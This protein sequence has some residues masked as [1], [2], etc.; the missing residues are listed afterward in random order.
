M[1][2]HVPTVAMLTALEMVLAKGGFLKASKE[3]NLSAAAISYTIKSLERLLGVALFERHADGVVPTQAAL[4]LRDDAKDVVDRACRLKL[5]AAAFGP[6]SGAIRI[7]APQ[8][9]ASLWL[10][11]RM[12]ELM[13]AFP[14]NRFEIISWLGGST[15]PRVEFADSVHLEIRWSG[16]ASLP[17]GSR[18]TLLIRD[19]AVAVASPRYL[20]KLGGRLTADRV[21]D[22]LVI[23][24][25]NWPGIW[26]RW[27]RAAFG[28]PLG[29]ADEIS[30]QN[31]ALGVQAAEGGIGI[32]IAHAPLIRDELAGGKL[33]LANDCAFRVREGYFMVQYQPVDPRFLADFEVWTKA[34]MRGPAG[35][36]E[37]IGLTIAPTSPQE[38]NHP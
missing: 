24:A 38:R 2:D 36:R 22:C 6:P 31:T 5:K 9:F 27:S 8:A 12:A 11:P 7:L 26:E 16:E 4:A 30:V 19:Q 17:K 35:S 3:L 1:R 20:Q 25:L 10:L 14:G 28:A 15:N 29:V 37:A 34:A 23:R 18:H 33:V 32:A 13:K 21:R